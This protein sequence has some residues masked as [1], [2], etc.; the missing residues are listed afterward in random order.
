M[1]DARRRF[2]ALHA[3]AHEAVWRY[4][5]RTVPPGDRDDVYQETWLVILR[6]CRDRALDVEHPR[7]YAVRVAR[8]RAIERARTRE[9][10]DALVFDPV[11]RAADD[12]EVAAA[13][14]RALAS[15]TP[16]QRE[17]FVLRH[18]AGLG[19][20]EIAAVLRVPEGTVASRIHGAVCAMR[21]VFGAAFGSERS[22]THDL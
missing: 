22:M 13:I 3:A 17:A 11:A 2:D 21:A 14:E 8:S 9:S 15:V 19:Y 1:T 20:A 7:A 12:G 6:A 16:E 4:V 5:R 18:E 10:V